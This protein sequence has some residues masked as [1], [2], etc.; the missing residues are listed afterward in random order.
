MNMDLLSLDRARHRLIQQ[1]ERQ[2]ITATEHLTTDQASGRILAQPLVAGFDIPP[3][4]NSAMD[5]YALRSGELELGT[6]LPVSQKIYAGQTPAP[7]APGSCARIFTGAPLPEGADA[8]EMQENTRVL[9]D[10]RIEFLSPVPAGRFVRPAGQD[11]QTGQTKLC[12]GVRLGPI[13]L[14]LAASLGITEVEVFAPLRVAL[15]SSGDELV[16]PGQP[17]HQGQ[18]YNANHPLLLDWLRRLGCQVHDLGTLPDQA[19]TIRSRLMAL[20]DIDL[21]LSTGGVSVGEA[22]VLGQILREEGQLDYWRLAL[23][24][25]KPTTFGQYRDIAFLGLP[26]NPVSSLVTFA[27][28]ARPYILRR[29]GMANVQPMSFPVPLAF[30][31]KEPGTR[32]EFLRVRFQEGRAQLYDNQCSSLLSSAAWANGLLELPEGVTCQP[33]DSLNFYPFSEFFG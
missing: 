13:E 16:T 11:A 4:P 33:G 25:G 1:A 29:M 30:A 3:W 17:L 24:P 20:T 9:G 18:I 26:G 8:V 5:G 12:T 10:G 21:L 27:L 22:D 31:I 28:L 32:R 23:K 2:Q 14:G 7:L 6:P 19:D 15:L